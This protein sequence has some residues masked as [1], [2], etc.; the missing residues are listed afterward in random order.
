MNYPVTYSM[1]VRDS[2]I[3]LFRPLIKSS[4]FDE[5]EPRL[6]IYYRVHSLN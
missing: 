4:D 1:L 3:R 2:L 6:F 5:K